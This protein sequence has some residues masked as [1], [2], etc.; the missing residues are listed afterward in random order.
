MDTTK[1]EGWP[2]S[3]SMQS[4]LDFFFKK[5]EIIDDEIKFSLKLKVGQ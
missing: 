2:N 5:N 3:L 4:I 1:V